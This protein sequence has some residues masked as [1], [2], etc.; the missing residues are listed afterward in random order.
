ML[1]K[2]DTTGAI[3]SVFGLYLY[4]DENVWFKSA[5]ASFQNVGQVLYG[6]VQTDDEVS[7]VDYVG[8]LASFVRSCSPIYELSAFS[9]FKNVQDGV[10]QM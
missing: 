5:T 9:T 8:C 2:A 4:F 3:H 6:E 7:L 10:S 1:Q